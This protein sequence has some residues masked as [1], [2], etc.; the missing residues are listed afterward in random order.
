MKIL[1]LLSYNFGH[2]SRTRRPDN[3]VPY[4]AGFRGKLLHNTDLCTACGT[5]VY[6]C[7]P[8]AIKISDEDATITDWDYSED[9]CTFCG[10]CVQYCPTHAL[11]FAQE[12]PV[13]ITER[14][15]HYLFHQVEMQPC[16]ECGKSVH[17][18]PEETLEQLYGKPLPAEIIETQGLCENCRQA[19][20]SKRFL[21]TVI[22]KGDRKND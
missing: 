20:I 12:S 11:S 9:R 14:V 7:S 19:L 15:Q 22:V 16:H 18:I 3:A 2:K 17:M 8:G 13:A 6:A 1:S 21:N 10:F 5:C 4:P